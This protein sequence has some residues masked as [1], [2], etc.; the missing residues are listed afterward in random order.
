MVKG[1]KSEIIFF[2]SASP[3]DSCFS[4]YVG[5]SGVTVVPTA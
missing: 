4:L 1:Q 2:G 3:E 5:K